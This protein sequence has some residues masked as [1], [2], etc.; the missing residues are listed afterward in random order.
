[1]AAEN[2]TIIPKEA[3]IEGKISFAGSISIDGEVKGDIK[4]G[5]TVNINRGSTV[6]ANI[7]T[8]NAVVSGYFEGVMNASGQV[9][10]KS[11]GKFVGDLVNEKSLLTIE[12]GGLFKGKSIVEE[13]RNGNQDRSAA[14]GKNLI[15]K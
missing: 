8:E 15:R 10:I 4:S 5:G 6:K 14:T 3:K 12:K 1:M 2:I 9:D 7:E 11:T 13:S